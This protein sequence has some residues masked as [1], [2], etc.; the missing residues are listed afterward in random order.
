LVEPA[1]RQ[2]R[3]GGYDFEV[4][5]V[6]AGE[7]FRLDTVDVQTRPWRLSE[8]IQEFQR[9]DIGLAPMHSEPVDQGALIGMIN[10]LNSMALPLVSV[11]CLPAE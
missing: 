6:G 7:D 11:E 3:A 9:I 10:C 1:L 5:V 4:H 8:E 2:L